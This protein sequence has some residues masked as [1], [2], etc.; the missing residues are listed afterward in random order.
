MNRRRLLVML[1]LAPLAALVP[2]TAGAAPEPI[3]TRPT[4]KLSDYFIWNPGKSY[5]CDMHGVDHSAYTHGCQ[6]YAFS[7]DMLMGIDGSPRPATRDAI[8][9]DVAR[10]CPF[11]SDLSSVHQHHDFRWID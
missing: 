11:T 3:D 5:L 4:F 6:P 8:P 9:G 2:A 1:P 7:R 10:D